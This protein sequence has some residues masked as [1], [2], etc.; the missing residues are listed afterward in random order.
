MTTPAWL[1]VLLA[2]I[3]MVLLLSFLRHKQWIDVV[4]WTGVQIINV[5][6]IWR[7]YVGGK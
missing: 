1:L 7:A 3:E 5:A 4:Y 2:A 6:L